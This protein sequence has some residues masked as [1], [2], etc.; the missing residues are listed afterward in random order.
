MENNTFWVTLTTSLN[1]SSIFTLE[2]MH[3]SIYDILEILRF[4]M[5]PHKY[6][7]VLCAYILHLIGTLL[8]PGLIMPVATRR[9]TKVFGRL[10]SDITLP[11]SK[12]PN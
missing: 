5:L 9:T 12:P 3:N 2:L 4:G 1:S 10:A 7:T 11:A 6:H 8:S